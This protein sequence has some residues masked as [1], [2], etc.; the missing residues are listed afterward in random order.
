MILH[1][2]RTAQQTRV[3]ET[4]GYRALCTTQ[5]SVQSG[6]LKDV[7]NFHR[8]ISWLLSSLR[9]LTEAEIKSQQRTQQRTKQFSGKKCYVP[10]GKGSFSGNP[11]PVPTHALHEVVL[12]A[13]VDTAVLIGFRNRMESISFESL[14]ARNHFAVGCRMDITTS[15]SSS[16]GKCDW[17]G[18]NIPSSAR[19]GGDL[20]TPFHFFLHIHRSIC[21]GEYV[22]HF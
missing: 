1:N 21:M 12:E 8:F 13:V 2:A 9:I 3:R 11:H 5:T 10:A 17:L 4:S 15:E 18:T 19:L 16:T 6:F 20:S 22:D 7:F 14:K